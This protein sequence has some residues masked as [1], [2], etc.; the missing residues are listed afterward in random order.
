MVVTGT[1]TV[2]SKY[3]CTRTGLKHKGE[4]LATQ[5]GRYIGI[6]PLDTGNLRSDA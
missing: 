3:K 6:H 4:I 5:F 2:S 1:V